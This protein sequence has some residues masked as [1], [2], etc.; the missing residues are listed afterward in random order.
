MPAKLRLKIENCKVST[1][2]GI[3]LLEKC[4]FP[5]AEAK[6]IVESLPKTLTFKSASRR[7]GT[8][9]LLQIGFNVKLT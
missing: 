6:E 2:D 7:F 1:E 8:F 4:G 5:A 9:K 3:K